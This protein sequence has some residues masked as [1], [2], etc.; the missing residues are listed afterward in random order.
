MSRENVEIVRAAYEAVERGDIDEATSLI[1]PEI[2]FH[3]YARSPEAGVYRG[4]DAVK[5]YN[6]VLFDQF[7]SIRFEIDDLVDAGERVVITT[8]Q[9]AVPKGGKAEM[10]VQVCEVWTVREGLLAERHS[11]STREQALEAAGLSD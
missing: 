7:E 9:H 5:K 11:Y 2:E 6:E 3:T 8:T 4:R 1:H 10:S